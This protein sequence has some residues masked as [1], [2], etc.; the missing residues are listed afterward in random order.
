MPYHYFKRLE[1]YGI[2]REEFQRQAALGFRWCY[3]GKHFTE[4]TNFIPS[5]QSN[6]GCRACRNIKRK[7]EITPYMSFAQRLSTHFKVTPEWYDFKLA[8]Q[9][10]HCALCPKTPDHRRLCFDHDHSCCPGRTTCG[11]CVR[12]LLCA[13]CNVKLGIWESCLLEGASVTNPSGWLLAADNYVESYRI[14]P[15][16]LSG[17]VLSGDHDG[18]EAHRC[19]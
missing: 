2:S 12:G 19:S 3:L 6:G 1:Q 9:N 14:N 15:R 18:K 17:L 13:Y 4:E 5:M 7:A 10:G 11:K 8:E 16:S